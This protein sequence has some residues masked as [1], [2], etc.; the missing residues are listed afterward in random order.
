MILFQVVIYLLRDLLFVASVSSKGIIKSHSFCFV[1]DQ[2][3][4]PIVNNVFILLLDTIFVLL[5]I[6][7]NLNADNTRA[8][9]Y[10][11]IYYDNKV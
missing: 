9:G 3:I 1:R 5:Y 4:F 8:L 2:A 11:V 10:W 6:C 7:S